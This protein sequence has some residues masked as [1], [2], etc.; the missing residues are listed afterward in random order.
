[1]LLIVDAPSIVRACWEA[2]RH[3]K[4]SKGKTTG[5]FYT[6]Y[7]A[8]RK[9][10]LDYSHVDRVVLIWEGG[11]NYRKQLFPD[12]KV[13]RPTTGLESLWQTEAEIRESAKYL[14]IHN[15]SIPG[16]EADDTASMIRRSAG[17]KNLYWTSDLD[18]AQLMKE[19]DIFYHYRRKKSY[20]FK[21][22]DALSGG[23]RDPGQFLFFKLLYG[24]EVD[25]VPGSGLGEVVCRAVAMKLATPANCELAQ[26]FLDEH[27]ERQIQLLSLRKPWMKLPE[28]RNF[29]MSY[30][31]YGKF[32]NYCKENEIR[33]WL[34]SWGKWTEPFDRLKDIEWQEIGIVG[35]ME[36][37]YLDVEFPEEFNKNST[38]SPPKT[39]SESA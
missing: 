10:I 36:F 8:L 23:F 24:D 20:L 27:Q 18:W 35:G 17:S 38:P 1:M 11:N 32:E 31:N 28:E 2:T 19:G 33:S 7:G 21:D 5:G 14:G 29:E 37:N 22:F 4:N 26:K 13:N 30:R 16:Y 12:Y 39:G 3:L 25:N 34:K 6:F 9:T 15:I